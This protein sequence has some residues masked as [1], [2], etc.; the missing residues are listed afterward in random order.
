VSMNNLAAAYRIEGKYAL[1]EPLLIKAL[2]IKRR[3]LGEIHRSTAAAWNNLAALYR[4]QGRLAEA[5]PVQLK[6]VEVWRSVSGDEGPETLVSMNNL[7]TLY[8]VQKRYAEAEALW[9]KVLESQRRVL[10]PKHPNTLE[11]LA[12]VGEA[13]I[14]LGKYAEAEAP[15][16]EVL[17]VW[18]SINADSWRRYYGEALVGASLAGQKRFQEAEPLLLSGYQGL[19]Q[20]QTSIPAGTRRVIGEAGLRV[21]DLYESWGQADKAVAWREKLQA[22]Q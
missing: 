20:R 2:A 17:G 7:A 22:K 11:V 13:R 6:A 5:E 21:G 18:Q 16:R 4:V 9:T 8:Q 14:Q 3:V 19:L 10:G 15:L 1:A 12:S